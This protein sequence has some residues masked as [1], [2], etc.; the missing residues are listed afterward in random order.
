MS[1]EK[2]APIVFVTSIL[3]PTDFSETAE[4]AFAHAL[5]IAVH[6]HARLTLLH[7]EQGAHDEWTQFPSVRKTLERWRL[8]PKGSPKS[9]VSD[10]LFV[11]VHKVQAKGKAPLTAIR[12][13]A[14]AHDVELIVLAT[15]GRAGL[16]RWLQPSVAEQTARATR[17]M[18]LV[19]PRRASR[20][21]SR[22]D[23]RVSLRRV[24]IPVDESPDPSSAIEAAAK[25]VNAHGFIT[26][27]E[28]GYD[29][30]ISV[31]TARHG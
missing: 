22:A 28:G 20:F 30:R 29:F 11:D 10:E 12:D 14:A 16:S 26:R 6:N 15:E 1:T 24:L 17:T 2:K 25:Y 7:S 31:E 19:V 27:L 21:V 4:E 8:L 3:H 18:T 13:Y 9:A 5:A 23:G